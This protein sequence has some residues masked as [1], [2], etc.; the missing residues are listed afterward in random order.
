MTVFQKSGISS[1]RGRVTISAKEYSLAVSPDW[2]LHWQ[3]SAAC[4][5]VL[6]CLGSR[7]DLEAT[8]V[9][10][11]V[12]SLETFVQDGS[13][14]GAHRSRVL[15]HHSSTAHPSWRKTERAAIPTPPS[16]AVSGEEAALAFFSALFM[17]LKTVFDRR[18]AASL[19]IHWL[20]DATWTHVASAIQAPA[21]SLVWFAQP[22]HSGT[23]LL[24][25]RDHPYPVCRAGK[26]KQIS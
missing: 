19:S 17:K 24:V 4:S 2:A 14:C 8:A 22:V 9:I 6:T 10:Q 5:P 21:A 7:A 23:Y 15:N 12:F 20:W 13:S 26:H 18:A 25:S 1:S 16:G 11:V 3:R